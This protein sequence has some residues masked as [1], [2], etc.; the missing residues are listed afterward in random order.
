MIRAREI[1]F[2]IMLI[3]FTCLRLLIAQE[4]TSAIVSGNVM[5]DVGDRG[6]A[7]YLPYRGPLRV[8]LGAVDYNY[9]IGKYEVTVRDWYC[10]L[11]AAAARCDQS[12][13]VDVHHLWNKEMEPWITCAEL[14][15]GS[16]FY[17]VVKGK[18]DFPITHVSLLSAMRYCNWI[19]QGS[20][21]FEAGED[22]DAITEY[23]SYNFSK[24]G[25]VVESED[26]HIY[27]PTQDEWIKAAYYKG[28][29]ANV[30]YWRYPTRNNSAPTFDSNY[31]H[32]YNQANY[33]GEWT[34]W[35]GSFWTGYTYNE[36]EK[37]PL[38]LTSVDFFNNSK[39]YYGCC[40]MGGNVNEWTI[41]F[42]SSGDYIVRGGSYQ[43][44]YD[45]LLIGAP[46]HAYPPEAES[47]LIG[48]RIVERNLRSDS[49]VSNAAND[50]KKIVIVDHSVKKEEDKEARDKIIS[51]LLLIALGVIG[52]CCL[53][54]LP[55]PCLFPGPGFSP[56]TWLACVA[57]FGV[58]T[59]LA[60]Y[61][62]VAM[63]ILN[64]Y[65]RFKK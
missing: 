51:D 61:D 30:G 39:S 54:L 65:R 44:S 42:T 17:E 4:T 60:I 21:V 10:F 35:H 49:T 31:H 20:P 43:S 23:R 57:G 45:D 15:D 25:S 34:G 38:A 63:S 53:L 5:V 18:E 16:H 32:N 14:S 9:Q 26:S 1:F 11:I 33:N 62:L 8:K 29:G 27:L 48:F 2:L 47:S 24:D 28:G 40:D 50:F 59:V 6:N 56:L 12:Q 7:G 64:F 52:I 41:T 37:A 13:L 46:L 58:I 19:E 55:V 3:S 36:D 22:I